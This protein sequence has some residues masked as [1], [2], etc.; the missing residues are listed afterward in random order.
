MMM[1]TWNSSSTVFSLRVIA[2]LNW[3]SDLFQKIKIKSNGP[4]IF[5]SRFC[6]NYYYCWGKRVFTM[7][8]AK[9]PLPKFQVE[10]VRW[11][12]RTINFIATT[13]WSLS[14]FTYFFFLHSHLIR[15]C[16]CQFDDT[17]V[18]NDVSDDQTFCYIGWYN[19]QRYFGQDQICNSA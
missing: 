10:Q 8:I 17:L 7:R 11:L 13:E 2:L 15:P 5:N 14:P 12:N 1:T 18:V 3:V 16:I 4:S 6:F 9:L 19:L